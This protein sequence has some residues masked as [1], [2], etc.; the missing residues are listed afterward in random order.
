MLLV[1]DHALFRRGLRRLL[2]REGI[3]VIGEGSHGRAAV[4]LA[5]EL[6]PDVIVMDLSMP[7]MS[8][9]EAIER[10]VAANPHA[11]ILVLTITAEED[12]VLDALLAGACGY[13]LKDARAEE[14][15]AGVRAA[16][17]GDSMI[18]PRIAGRLVTRLREVGRPEVDHDGQVEAELTQRE[19][20]ILRLIAS[21][22]ENAAIAQELYISPK[23][24]KNHV[25]AILDKLEIENRI[26]AAVV[27]V[28]CGLA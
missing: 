23:T 20:E 16:V 18:S 9:L 8:G 5:A 11:R 12:E 4:Q 22:K 14:I 26:Q 17:A 25:A 6:R 10:I 19:V 28:R 1:D 21:G 24:V 3:E 27:A 2:E 15:V 7:L 13:L